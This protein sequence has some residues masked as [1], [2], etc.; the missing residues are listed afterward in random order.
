MRKLSD[1][2]ERIVENGKFNY[3]VFKTPFKNLNMQDAEL[4]GALR[5]LPRPL[6]KLR[7]KDWQ[8]YAIIHPDFYF[9]TVIFNAHFT[10]K[11][12]FY[13]YDRRNGRLIEYLKMPLSHRVHV[14]ENLFNGTSSVNEKGFSIE[15]TNRIGEGHHDIKIDIGECGDKPAVKCD[16]QVLEDTTATQPLIVSL[17]LG[18]N[19]SMYSHKV[20]CPAAGTIATGGETV[21]LEPGRDIALVDVH[22]AYYPHHFWWKWANFAGF[23]SSGKIIGA[24]LTDNLIKDQAAW[25]ECA[26]WY[27]GKL[28]LLGPITFDFDPAETTR[29]WHIRDS[30]GRVELDFVPEKEK[31]EELN[32]GL[33]RTH[34]RQPLG[35]FNGYLVDDSGMHHEVREIFGVAEHMDSHL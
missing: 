34:Y 2:P 17:P 11:A 14:A 22:K 7:L 5:L 30:E 18:G 21:T 19:R 20:V 9:G 25:N 26:V 12:F 1:T 33:F 16:I 23:D 24:N 15:Y 4:A 35:C 29:P 10:A 6:R 32:L 3:G 27:D 8:H 13:A 31:I 28:S